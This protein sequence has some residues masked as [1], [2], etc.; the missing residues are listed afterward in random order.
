MRIALRA[1]CVALLAVVACKNAG[2]TLTLPGLF[3]GVVGVGVYFDRDASHTLTAG[4]TVISGVRI[5]LL[6]Q[7]GQDTIAVASTDAS[8]VAGFTGVPVGTYRF[9]V[10]RHALSDTI[11]V[12]VGDTGVLRVL[13]R[14][15][16]SQATSIVRLGYSEPTIAQVRTMPAGKRVFLRGVVLS[17]L[18][19]FRDSAAFIS[20]STG[21]LRITGSRHRPGR[22]G[23][24]IGDSVTV[25]GTTG[26][27]EGQP[28]L[29]NGLFGSLAA[30]LAPIPVSVSY[31]D[32][33]TAKNGTLD[34]ALVEI[35]NGKISDTIPASPDFLVRFASIADP[36]IKV[37]ALIDQ[38]LNAPHGFF[39]P[40]SS[41]TVRGV[42]VPKGDGT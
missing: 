23:N 6:A 22:T 34:A 14:P 11:G 5:A 4:D 13:A 33:R 3:Q 19:V 30:G 42:L 35:T 16:S 36:N 37:D 39:Q 25:L 40:G 41:F 8:G 32:A 17:P 26:L 20:D 2:E 24:N 31:A 18:Q 27:R 7:N 38:L 28:V 29:I 10:D 15:D 12:V 9:T 1:S 21:Y